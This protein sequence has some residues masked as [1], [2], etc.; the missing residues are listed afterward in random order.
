MFRGSF[1]VRSTTFV[2]GHSVGTGGFVVATLNAATKRVATATYYVNATASQPIAATQFGNRTFATTHVVEQLVV[3][4][5]GSVP[6]VV[7]ALLTVPQF[8]PL[9]RVVAHDLLPDYASVGAFID[10]YYTGDV[11][12]DKRDD[13]LVAFGQY[14]KGGKRIELRRGASSL[15]TLDATLVADLTVLGVADVDGDGAADVV[16]RINENRLVG[17]VGALAPKKSCLRVFKYVA[18]PSGG[19]G[20]DG[21]QFVELD[22]LQKGSKIIISQALDQIQVPALLDND[23]LELDVIVAFFFS[24]FFVQCFQLFEEGNVFVVDVNRDGAADVVYAPS[25]E[26][27]VSVYLSDKLGAFAAPSDAPFKRTTRGSMLPSEDVVALGDVND[28]ALVDL[29][30]YDKYLGS[31]RFVVG[32][33]KGNFKPM[34][35]APPPTQA[36]MFIYYLFIY[37]YYYYYLANS[38]ITVTKHCVCEAA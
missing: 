5:A 11:D 8:E 2:D 22:A 37:Y 31:H 15:A 33:G 1:D 18:K 16:A 3:D 38:S 17:T 34:A 4:V 14:A 25:D 23:N 7:G 9:G 36:L 6:L 13:L 20:D 24:F 27:A 29:H 21:A 26:I 12:G 19:S 28:D 35:N 30:L 10:A 32:D